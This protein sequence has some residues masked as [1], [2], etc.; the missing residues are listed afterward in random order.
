MA[1]TC[2][3]SHSSSIDTSIDIYILIN[4]CLSCPYEGHL[5][6]CCV[7]LLTSLYLLVRILPPCLLDWEWNDWLL[8]YPACCIATVL[9]LERDLSDLTAYL[10]YG[11]ELKYK[12]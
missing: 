3:P 9:R 8:L 6:S 10:L 11:Q 7:L 2:N 4:L 1:G 12:A 5:Q